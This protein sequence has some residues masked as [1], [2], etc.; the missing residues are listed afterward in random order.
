MAQGGVI[1]LASGLLLFVGLAMQGARLPTHLKGSY[2]ALVVFMLV[3][4]FSMLSVQTLA[5]VFVWAVI[6][7]A[8]KRSAGGH[9]PSRMVVGG[10][11]EKSKSTMV[12][13]YSGMRGMLSVTLGHRIR[14]KDGAKLR[15]QLE[16]YLP[17]RPVQT[18]QRRLS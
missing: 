16:K 1:G 6:G 18:A 11:R 2:V 4:G 13:R 17:V 7:F 8:T 9:A 15:T 10:R 14:S 5:C 3:N 12:S